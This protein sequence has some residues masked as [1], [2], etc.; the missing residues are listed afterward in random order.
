MS[1]HRWL[2]MLVIAAVTGACG[3]EAPRDGQV[4]ILML[5]SSRRRSRGTNSIAL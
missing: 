1:A 5:R 2:G 3:A 4:S